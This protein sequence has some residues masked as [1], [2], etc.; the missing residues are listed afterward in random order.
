M[1]LPRRQTV[2]RMIIMTGRLAVYII[3][4]SIYIG[5]SFA[6]AVAV[7]ERRGTQHFTFGE[8]AF[9]K[10]E[11][12]VRLNQSPKAGGVDL[13]VSGWLEPERDVHIWVN[14]VL[15]K[16]EKYDEYNGDTLSVRTQRRFASQKIESEE[17]EG[18]PAVDP[19]TLKAVAQPFVLKSDW[20]RLRG[21]EYDQPGVIDELVHTA[22]SMTKP[23]DSDWISWTPQSR[24]K[25]EISNKDDVLV[26]VGKCK[27]TNSDDYYGANLPVIKTEALLRIA[28]KDMADLLLDSS[29][30][31][32]YNK[33]SIGRSDV[34]NIECDKG[35][36]KI[37]KNV[38]KPPMTKKNIESVT[39]MH[40]RQL[41]EKGTYIVVSRAVINP[42]LTNCKEEKKEECGR[43]EILIGVNLLEPINDNE[44]G[45][46]MT[47][48]THVYSP[49]L[50][51]LVAK[52]V[53]VN[54][55]IN[56]VN[57]IRSV[58]KDKN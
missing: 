31:K 57:D 32:V 49:A 45:S 2:Y 26:Y 15:L 3:L 10:A 24:K 42:E 25:D 37:V 11:D 38:T 34:R 53:G 30:V 21:N 14:N 35:V 40:S 58:C 50:P 55:A 39:F 41:D 56:F 46:K 8:I 4:F 23:E 36:A 1:E 44:L 33:M 47:S 16:K 13:D 29:R 9:P 7:T 27:K 52:R 54:S 43:S 51:V 22:I 20:S 28:P 17:E 12:S 5:V 6:S 18:H 19:Y 48:I